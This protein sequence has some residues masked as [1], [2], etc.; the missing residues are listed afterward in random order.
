MM[1][2]WEGP[3]FSWEVA[4]VPCVGSWEGLLRTQAGRTLTWRGGH[5]QSHA[6]QDKHCTHMIVEGKDGGGGAGKGRVFQP[7]FGP[8]RLPPKLMFP[9]QNTSQDAHK[10]VSRAGYFGRPWETALGNSY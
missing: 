2:A 10:A 1:A 6:D 9:G 3:P 7:G 5:L 4:C 8:M